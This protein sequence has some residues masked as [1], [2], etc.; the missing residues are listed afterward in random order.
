MRL[1]DADALTEDGLNSFVKSDRTRDLIK[2]IQFAPTI[3][4]EPVMHGRWVTGDKLN[5]HRKL[6][7][8]HFLYCSEC[9]EEAYWDTDYGQQK[10]D[11]CP[12][13]GTKMD[14]GADHED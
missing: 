4:A 6:L 5:T 3:E 1:I 12:N 11:Y 7:V 14:G 9:G 2:H 8:T 10:F 13:C